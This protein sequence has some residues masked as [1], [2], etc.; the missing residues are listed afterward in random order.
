MQNEH[1]KW[2]FACMA[3]C[4]TTLSRSIF[5]ISKKYGILYE[6]GLWENILTFQKWQTSALIESLSSKV[7]SWALRKH[8]EVSKHTALTLRVCGLTAQLNMGTKVSCYR[9]M[10]D[11][12]WRSTS[13][14]QKSFSKGQIIGS[15][16]IIWADGPHDW[17]D[18]MRPV[19]SRLT[20]EEAG[21]MGHSL[22]SHDFCST[23]ECRMFQRV[24]SKR[25]GRS[26]PK[27]EKKYF[28][29]H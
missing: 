4:V 15:G 10:P 24:K 5:Q 26:L 8:S 2:H 22:N 1:L 12:H 29:C 3:W 13:C 6:N 11:T 25:P 18:S 17:R 16:P 27:T 28:S 9:Q 23:S 14:I 20:D 21:K 19:H 7:I